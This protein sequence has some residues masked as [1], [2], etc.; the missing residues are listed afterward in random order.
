MIILIFGATGMNGKVLFDFFSKK[1]GYKVY[2]TLRDQSL[3]VFFDKS[4]HK[5]LINYSVNNDYSKLEN[6]INTTKPDLIINCIGM[7]KHKLFEREIK[8]IYE[9]NSIFPNK[10][11]EF[12]EVF[13]CRMIHFSTDCVFLGT[14][15][16]YNEES[17][18]DSIDDYG[19]SKLQGEICDSKNV[20]TIRLSLIGHEINS[21][22]QLIDWFL[23]QKKS[24]KGY[25]KAIFSGITN[26]EL[27]NVIN[28]YIIQNSELNGLYHISAKPIDKFAVLDMTSKIYNKDI[29]ILPD[30][31]VCVDRS[32]NSNKFRKI[33]SYNPPSWDEMLRKLYENSKF[34][35]TN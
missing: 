23:S 1:K 28:K 25:K 14:K 22:L 7:I 17:V 4:S 27:F 30:E 6:I 29:A 11:K 12:C 24:V 21:N 10:L 20:L 32:L 3:K 26:I 2:G 35:N 31:S 33:T 15:G 5:N 34:Y 8:K 18:P 9:I 19:K 13:N 16:N